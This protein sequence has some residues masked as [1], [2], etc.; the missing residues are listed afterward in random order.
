MSDAEMEAL[1]AERQAARKR[2]DFA[3]SDRL[4]D[5]L[6]RARDYARGFPRWRRA[7]EA[8]VGQASACLCLDVNAGST[9]L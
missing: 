3:A 2:R 5:E 4:R 9:I 1:V 7:L 8:E 6:G